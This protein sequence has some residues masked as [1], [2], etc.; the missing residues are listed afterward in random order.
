MFSTNEGRASF[1]DESAIE[2]AGAIEFNFPNGQRW[3]G[4]IIEEIPARRYV[5]EYIG[6]SVA[7]IDLAGD[8]SG[9]TV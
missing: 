2:T 9:G 6:G 1:W 3:R 7:S 4:R 5:V 8:G